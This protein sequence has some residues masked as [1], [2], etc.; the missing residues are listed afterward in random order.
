MCVSFERACDLLGAD[1]CFKGNTFCLGKC[2]CS[3]QGHPRVKPSPAIDKK[4]NTPLKKARKYRCETKKLLGFTKRPPNRPGKRVHRIGNVLAKFKEA[5]NMSSSSALRDFNSARR[6]VKP[7]NRQ[8]SDN[9]APERKVSP[10]IC[11]VS[12]GAIPTADRRLLTIDGP[13]A[14][15]K[16]DG[17]GIIELQFWPIS[18][19]KL[20]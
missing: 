10:H 20:F 18:A 12:S 15:G 13:L 2:T 5:H 9:G 19:A 17:A 11:N 3:F 8:P 14:E 6:K 4:S 1:L 7:N 16:I